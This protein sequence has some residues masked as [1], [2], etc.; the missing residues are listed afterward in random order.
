[1]ASLLIAHPKFT[2]LTGRKKGRSERQSPQT[3]ASDTE[4][5]GG[6]YWDRTSG[7]HRV[8]VALYR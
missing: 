5:G 2:S 8:K 7:F 3:R 6:R 1:M 4:I